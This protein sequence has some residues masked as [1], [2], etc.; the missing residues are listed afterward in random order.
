[1]RSYGFGT[2]TGQIDRRFVPKE[3]LD[4][5]N[6]LPLYYEGEHQVFVHAALD[7]T[8]DMKDQTEA[9]L[10]WGYW[11]GRDIDYRGKYICHGHDSNQNVPKIGKHRCNM[12][13]RSFITNR[14]CVAVFDG[15]GQ[16]IEIMEIKG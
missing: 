5:I 1:M 4:W 11:R 9:M 16:P 6:S 15:P 12:D 14:L 7:P 10:T 13:V 3:H 8:K 2:L